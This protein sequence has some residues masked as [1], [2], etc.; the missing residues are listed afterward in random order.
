ME[1]LNHNPLL[2]RLRYHNKGGDRKK[3][4]TKELKNPQMCHIDRVMVAVTACVSGLS[5][6]KNKAHGFG[7]VNWL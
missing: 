2:L 3:N 4:M 1:H 7:S 6:F 5:I